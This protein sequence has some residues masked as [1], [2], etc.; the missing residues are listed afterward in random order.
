MQ[1]NYFYH[2]EASLVYLRHWF[3]YDYL[4]YRNEPDVDKGHEAKIVEY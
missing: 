4:Y 1:D 3:H 2:F